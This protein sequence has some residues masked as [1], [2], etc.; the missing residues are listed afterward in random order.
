[1]QDKQR[2]DT[3]LDLLEQK[4]QSVDKDL[5]QLVVTADSLEAMLPTRR[6]H[7]CAPLRRF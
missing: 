3:V 7:R 6:R 2:F 4:L 5:T 1:M